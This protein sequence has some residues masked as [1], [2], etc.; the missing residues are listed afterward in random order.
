MT[1]NILL[2]T[3]GQIAY[4]RYADSMQLLEGVLRRAGMSVTATHDAAAIKNLGA[5]SAVVLFTDGD[6]FDDAGIESLAT[7]VRSGCGLVTLHTAAGTNK[8]SATMGEL[9]GSRVAGGSIMEHRATV[10]D[11][12]HPIMHRAVDFVLDDEVHILEPVTDFRV[13]MTAWLNGKQQPLA[14]TKSEGAGRVVHFA[15][16]HSLKGLS[17]PEWQK[18]FIRAVRYVSGED[19]QHRTIKCACIG[20][21]GAFNMGKSHLLSCQ[22]AR[23]MPVAVCDVDPRRTQTAQAELGDH[24]QAYSSVAELLDRS[25]AE[26]VIV[27]TPHNTHAPLSMQ[28]LNSGRHVVTEKPYTITVEEA[29]EVIETAQRMQKMATVFHN[30]RWDG[31]FLAIKQ[32]IASG[33]IGE[34]FHIECAFGE[35]A[36]PRADWWR[37]SK[38]V[39][40]GALYDWGAHFVDWVLQL[41]PHKIESVSGDFKKL[42]WHGVTVEDYTSA[43]IRFDGQRS[44]SF[45]QGS[46]NAIDKP[47]WRI[48]GTLGGIEKK[49]WDWDS[50][51][52]L[53]L[54]SY[55]SG[56]RVESEVPYGK[57]DWDGFYRNIADHLIVGEPLAVTPESARKVIAV[58]SLAEQS[59]QLGG[60][61]MKLGFAQ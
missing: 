13:L 25:D 58:L 45:E 29:T 16:G 41:I 50:V 48:L 1:H 11:A 20:Y 61:P 51:E 18:L 14:Y 6:Y 12:E 31:D 54:V 40:G 35:Y 8:G 21:G 26:M 46:I 34:V 52:P 32:I 42:K 60:A 30:R 24:I 7:F 10:V 33:A 36:E 3:G 4:H 9:I 27:I 37:A 17:H 39:S 47:R 56:T 22:R 49:N 59:S 55:A 2:I 19:W 15:T 23:M 57:P 53:K 28:V 5:Y 44:A 43:Y 38:S